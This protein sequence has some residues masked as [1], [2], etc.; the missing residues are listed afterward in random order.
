MDQIAKPMAMAP[1]VSHA[2]RRWP[3]EA[4]TRSPESKAAYEATIAITTDSATKPA[5]YV[6]AIIGTANPL[7][8]L[9]LARD[10]HLELPG[11]VQYTSVRLFVK[12][13]LIPAP[14]INGSRERE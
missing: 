13:A 3:S 5:L 11:R 7:L 6:P 14:A 12:T 2:Q 8:E 4:E 1:L 9:S 10:L